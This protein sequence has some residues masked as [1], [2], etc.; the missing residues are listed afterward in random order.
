MRIGYIVTAV[1]SLVGALS[2][3]NPLDRSSQEVAFPILNGVSNP[4]YFC[5]EEPILPWKDEFHAGGTGYIDGIR[6]DDLTD[7]VMCGKDPWDRSFMA[8]KYTCKRED[9]DETTIGAVAIFQRYSDEALV[10]SGGH[11]KA[12]GCELGD[13]NPIGNDRFAETAARFI[14][15]EEVSV[16]GTENEKIST[17]KICDKES[18]PD[19][20]LKLPAPDSTDLVV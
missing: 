15:G 2:G 8:L 14:D 20:L 17:M 1:E 5:T 3:M 6:P 4:K 7:P 11:Y 16:Y 13:L 19:P 12:R 18:C 9:R 10:V